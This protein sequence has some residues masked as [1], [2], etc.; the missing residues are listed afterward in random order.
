MR[1][2]LG[3]VVLVLGVSGCGRQTGVLITTTSDAAVQPALEPIDELQFVIGADNGVAGRYVKDDVN[4]EVRVLVTGRDLQTQPYKLL[5]Q[6]ETFKNPP[7]GV[8]VAV[9]GWANNQKVAFGALAAPQAFV[10]GE[11]LERRIVLTGAVDGTDFVYT[12]LGCLYR[13]P[14]AIVRYDDRDC[15]GDPTSTDCNDD[16]AS[17][18]HA[19][20]EIC[21]NS[22]DDNCDGQ[23]DEGCQTGCSDGDVKPCYTGPAGTV[24]KGACRTGR[25]TCAGGVYGVCIG[26]VTPSAEACNG[27]DDN[28]NGTVDENL[29]MV[30]CGLGACQRSVAACSGGLIQACTPGT[31]AA[32][33]AAC[34]GVD[35]DCDGAIDEDCTCVHVAPTGNDTAATTDSNVT[36]FATVQAAIDWAAGDPT[37]PKRVCVAAGATCGSTVGY[38]G[39]VTLS[40][41]ISV[42]GGYES[43]TFTSCTSSVVTLKPVAAAGILVPASVVSTTVLDGFQIERSAT[44]IQA[45]VTVDGASNVILSNLAIG[46]GGTVTTSYGINLINGGAATITRSRIFGGNGTALSVGVH[47]DGGKPTIRDNCPMLDAT[48]HCAT[49]CATLSGGNGIRGRL[50]GATG[51]SYA[52]FLKNSP[53]ASVEQTATCGNAATTGAGVR[54]T[55]DS[56]GIVIRQSFIDAYGGTA[57]SHGLWLEDC[58]DGSPWIVD[59]QHIGGSGTTIGARVDGIRAIGACHP[60]VDSNVVIVGGSEGGAVSAVGV[61]CGASASSSR[62][63]VFGNKLIQGSAG[64]FPPTATAVRC[65]DGACLRVAKN[66]LAGHSGVDVYGLWLGKTGTFV[67]NNLISGGCGTASASGVYAVD[68]FARLENN[69][70]GA[71][72]CANGSASTPLFFGLRSQSAS[73][74]NELDVT[75]NDLDG[76]GNAIACKSTGVELKV[77]AARAP[78]KPVGMFR[79]NIVRGGLCLTARTVFAEADS[80]A[81]PRVLENNDFDPFQTPTTLYL[82]EATTNLTTT[83][84]INALGGAAANLSVDAGFV[85]YPN[86]LHLAATSMCIGKGTATGAAIQDMDGMTRKKPS[87]I[88]AD[89]F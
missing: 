39:D 19:A 40:D 28:C 29:G 15:D 80:N 10:A 58:D 49:S 65:D 88:G 21:G 33:D 50:T 34:D 89:E 36:P 35:N 11:V 26:Q 6:P 5:L 57:D 75:N 45:A 84:A 52:V 8:F 2:A 77:V 69:R 85:A 74:G 14:M 82:D 32:N 51:E 27:E 53:N 61:Y 73:G 16:D 71:G 23:V 3:L 24:G 17:I 20:A 18:N 86:N 62:C 76:G 13:G 46:P 7:P 56:G 68:A 30:V 37:R 59:N 60:I 44:P 78:S 64:G 48:G 43:T 55:G 47:S 31:P 79:N 41:G 70:V 12:P 87:D 67:D 42:Y 63:L 4:P 1:N 83:T 54:V 25:Q 66:V 22:V 81:D 9:I 72:S 38:A